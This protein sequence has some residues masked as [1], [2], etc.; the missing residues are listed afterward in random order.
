MSNIEPTDSGKEKAEVFQ[1]EKS[2]T[3]TILENFELMS[4]QAMKEARGPLNLNNLTA[5]QINKVLDNMAQNETNSFEYHIRKLEASKEIELRR[6]DASVINQKTIKFVLI[7][8]IVF[9]LPVITLI[10]LLCKDSFF[11]PWLTF[12]TGIMGGF[13]LSKIVSSV[14]APQTAKNSLKEYEESK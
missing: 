12:L 14:F 6:I 4:M 13:G 5:E 3:E 2:K 8:I 11:I 9:V 7:G 1:K 10:I